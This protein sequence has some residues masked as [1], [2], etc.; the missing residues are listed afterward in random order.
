MK[1][2]DIAVKKSI[3]STVRIVKVDWRRTAKRWWISEERC[4]NSIAPCVGKSDI[5]PGPT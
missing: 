1:I 4:V 2:V 3:A 5:L